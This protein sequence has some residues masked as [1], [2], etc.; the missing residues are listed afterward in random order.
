MSAPRESDEVARSQSQPSKVVS[1][2]SDARLASFLPVVPCVVRLL[3]KQLVC[4]V[5]LSKL[6]ASSLA[7]GSINGRKRLAN[8]YTG[9]AL[10]MGCQCVAMR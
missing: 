2:A 8:E 1:D 3:R 10:I 6:F 5:D 4:Q 7:S 9:S